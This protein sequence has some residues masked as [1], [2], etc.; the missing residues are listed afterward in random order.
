MKKI[1]TIALLLFSLTSFSQEIRT[2]NNFSLG[3][4]I[5]STSTSAI[6]SYGEMVQKKSIVPFRVLTNIN[7]KFQSY[8]KKNDIGILGKNFSLL[9]KINT[10]NLAIPLGFEVFQKNLG[11]GISQELV[12]FGF[13]KSYDSTQISDSRNYSPS[14]K[15][16]TTIFSKN[17][18]LS[19]QIYLV[20]TINESFAIKL[21][22]QRENLSLNF[23]DKNDKTK[24]GT[25]HSN[26]IFISI[27]T[28]IEK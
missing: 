14:V 25:I 23:L 4:G 2:Y 16:F 18:S 5:S 8:N 26:S 3:S 20:Y 24:T 27:R 9:K 13:K 17:Q 12:S 11:L 15:R 7:I 28:N 1:L 10:V 22:A 6:V 21:G 19:G